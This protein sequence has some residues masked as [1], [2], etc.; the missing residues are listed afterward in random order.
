MSLFEFI[1]KANSEDNGNPSSMRVNTMWMVF[2]FVLVLSFGFVV[3]VFKYE[4][5]IISFA[6]LLVGAVLGALGIKKSQKGKEKSSNEQ[7]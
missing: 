7:Q 5:I 1:R 2:W 3:A 6:V 4:G